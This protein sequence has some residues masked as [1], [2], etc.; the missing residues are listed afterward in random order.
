MDTSTFSAAEAG[1]DGTTWIKVYLDQVH[2]IKQVKNYRTTATWTCTKDECN[3]CEGYYCD[4]LTLTI[5]TEGALESEL[6][7]YHYCRYGDTVKL[8][9]TYNQ[10]HVYE[11]A[12]IG[13]LGNFQT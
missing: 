9:M 4:G 12:I 3:D 7:A 8:E 2:C 13:K 10:L 1:P 5:S 6:P 11:V